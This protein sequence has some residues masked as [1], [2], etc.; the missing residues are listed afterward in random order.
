MRVIGA[1]TVP[2]RMMTSKSDLVR[3]LDEIFKRKTTEKDNQRKKSDETEVKISIGRLDTISE[4]KDSPM[5]RSS[6]TR[7]AFFSND[8]INKAAQERQKSRS[9]ANLPRP[10]IKTN[11]AIV[12]RHAKPSL[13][14][15]QNIR[16]SLASEPILE[17][18]EDKAS[19]ID[20]F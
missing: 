19:D 11:S 7:S 13:I 16:D 15:Q 20:D 3:E 1:D 10:I 18:E 2:K 12:K 5:D 6:N 8:M 14:T 17:K 4:S 9:F